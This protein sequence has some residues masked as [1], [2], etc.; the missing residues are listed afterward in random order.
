MPC[1]PIRTTG[2]PRITAPVTVIRAKTGERAGNL[3]FSVSPTWP[4][5]GAALGA[6]RDEQWADQSHFIP[7]EAPQRLADLIATEF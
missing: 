6:V 7:M 5:L 2:W 3:D 4:G 1:V